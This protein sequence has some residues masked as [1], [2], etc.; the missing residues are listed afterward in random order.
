MKRLSG[1]TLPNRYRALQRVSGKKIPRCVI[2]GEKDAR[3]LT[4]NHK[5]GGGYGKNA[6]SGFY[7]KVMN[8]KIPIKYLNVMCYNCNRLFEYIRGRLSVPPEFLKILPKSVRQRMNHT[9]AMIRDWR[10]N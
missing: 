8:G 9:D 1:K 6:N 4:F 5:K 7:S 3:L 2:C 10:K